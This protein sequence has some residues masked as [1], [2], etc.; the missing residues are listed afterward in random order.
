VDATGLPRITAGKTV[1]MGN[2]RPDWTGG[3]NNR[4]SYKQFS[5]SFLISAR[6]GGFVS[7]FTNAVIF[8]DGVTEQTLSGRDSYVFPGVTDA[9]AKNTVATTAERYWVKVGGRNTPA[10]EVFT[11]DASN[12]RL[13]ELVLS[14]NLPNT[15][16]KGLPFQSASLSMVGRNLFFLMNKAV[17]F[18]PEL[19]AG[20]QNTTVG[21]ESFSMPSTRSLGVNLNIV[22]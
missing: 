2:S 16:I 15:L 3:L 11:Y 12:I 18:D 9:G 22:F 6:M 13:R 20:A 19:T 5:L 21:L 4:I 17:G 10:G 8:A 7:S 1:F 14:Y